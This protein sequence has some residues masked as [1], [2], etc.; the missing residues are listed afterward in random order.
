MNHYKK[1]VELKRRFAY[2]PDGR[3]DTW[4]ILGNEEIVSGD[5]DDFAVTISYIYSNSGLLRMGWNLLTFQHTF[6]LFRTRSG[7]HVCLYVRKLGW[8][9]NIQKTIFTELPDG[10][11]KLVPYPLPIVLFKMLIGKFIK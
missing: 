10:Y 3:L 9:D 1:L 5:C 8:V 4:R 7:F 11:K 2:R 6:W